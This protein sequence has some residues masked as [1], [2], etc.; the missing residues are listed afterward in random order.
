M[1][2][3]TI[4]LCYY[5][6]SFA[7]FVTFHWSFKLESVQRCVW[8]NWN[9]VKQLGL[10]PSHPKEQLHTNN[11]WFHNN[12]NKTK[13]CENTSPFWFGPPVAWRSRRR[14]NALQTS[15]LLKVVLLKKKEASVECKK[16]F[17]QFKTVAFVL[18]SYV[19]PCALETC[20][21][22]V[23]SRVSVKLLWD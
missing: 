19:S 5:Q 14:A 7:S 21:S 10:H 23:L 1:F 11:W 17:L 12:K 3:E 16:P 4:L 2:I 6:Y 13:E 8:N 22:Q 20:S 15:W 18:S 9:T